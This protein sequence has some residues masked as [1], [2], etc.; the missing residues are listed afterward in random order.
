MPEPAKTD[1]LRLSSEATWFYRLAIPLLAA[2]AGQEL[3]PFG[4]LA[5]HQVHYAPSDSAP[6]ILVVVPAIGILTSLVIRVTRLAD[7]WLCGDVL[8]T[9]TLV[10][11]ASIPL[12]AVSRLETGRWWTSVIELE[13]SSH[14]IA[15]HEFCSFREAAWAAFYLESVMY[16]R[17][18]SAAFKGRLVVRERAEDAWPSGNATSN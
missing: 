9:R 6:L 8:E 7:V 5:I 17:C 12:A 3:I 14:L 13:S 2:V 16:V 15:L 11:K 4:R 10:A 1:R 18:W